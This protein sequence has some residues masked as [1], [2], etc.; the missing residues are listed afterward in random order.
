MRRNTLI[1]LIACIIIL[2]FTGCSNI[3]DN[4]ILY[5]S[6]PNDFYYTNLL[7]QDLS[8]KSNYK[9]TI[10]DTNYYREIEFNKEYVEQFKLFLKRLNKSNFIK[11]PDKELNKPLYKIFFDFGNEKYIVNVYN[12]NLIS[13]YPWDGN[14]E[15]DFINMT[16]TPNSLNIYSLCKY[17]Y[18]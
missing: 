2:L 1:T 11:K 7:W 5:P 17:L 10:L 15:M 9:T 16:D 14:Y 13:I 4:K 18:N 8:D 3:I 12:E 6:K